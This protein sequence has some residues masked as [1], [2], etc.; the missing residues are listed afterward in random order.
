M[1]PVNLLFIYTDEQAFNTLAC[2]G[3]TLIDMPHLNQLASKSTVFE[4]AYVS[5]PVC[6]PSRSTLLTGLWPH[7]TGCTSNN[8]P[9]PK[10]SKCFPEMLPDEYVTGHFGKWHLGDEIFAQ[11]GFDEWSNYE[12]HYIRYYSHGHNADAR[13]DYHHYLLKQGYEPDVKDKNIF[14]REFTA[15]L[16]EER[17]KP[18][19]TAERSIDFIKHHSD[20]PFALYVNF[21]EPHMP[22]F[23][24]RDNQYNPDKIP[25]PKNFNNVPAEDM[26]QKYRQAVKKYAEKGMSGLQLDSD[27]DWRKIRANYWGLCS[28]I[29]THAGHIFQALKDNNLWD[30][31]LIVFTSDHGDM[32]GAH[33]LIAKCVMYEEAVRVPLLIKMPRQQQSKLIKG[34]MSHIDLLPT[35]LDIMDINIPRQLHGKSLKPWMLAESPRLEDD[36]FIEWNSA[37]LTGNAIDNGDYERTIITADGWKYV[38]S[39]AGE[40][41]LFNLNNDPLETT[42]L[43]EQYA[44][45]E[46][47]E[48]LRLRIRNWQ[49]STVDNIIS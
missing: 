39:E 12:D 36:I 40:H 25:L 8:I 22:F 3:N 14:S 29:D 20:Q 16:P 1:N 41:I 42:N 18:A 9:L 11:H 46:L 34:A 43:Y 49:Q 13:S 47:V 21:I 23:S 2:Y 48:N 17:S 33:K 6:T 31:T 4:R 35:L 24:S 15:R 5:Q 19:Y 45:S 26:P 28:L 38:H 32:M 10:T 27:D 30:N 37:D 7:C 44:C